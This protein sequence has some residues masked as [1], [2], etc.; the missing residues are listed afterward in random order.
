MLWFSGRLLHIK[1]QPLLWTLNLVLRPVD[2][3]RLLDVMSNVK[4]GLRRCPVIVVVVIVVV[5]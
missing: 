3:R 1:L 2:E 4:R 5:V